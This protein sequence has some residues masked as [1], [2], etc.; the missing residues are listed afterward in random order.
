MEEKKDNKKKIIILAIITLIIL[1]LATT[2]S[3]YIWNSDTNQDI[4]VALG[5]DVSP[6][7]P[8]GR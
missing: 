7:R 3:F 2:F 6:C 1:T 5:G 8:T 4:D